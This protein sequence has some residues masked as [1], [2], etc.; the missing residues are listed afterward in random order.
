MVTQE[1]Y[2]AVVQHFLEELSNELAVR[3]DVFARHPEVEE[4]AAELLADW[5]A[6]PPSDE[7][8]LRAAAALARIGI[9]AHWSSLL[10]DAYADFLRGYLAQARGTVP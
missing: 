2:A 9:D 5:R 4:R 8:L 1:Q 6:T 10:P 7:E 3:A